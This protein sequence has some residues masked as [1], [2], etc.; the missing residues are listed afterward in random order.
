MVVDEKRRADAFMPFRFPADQLGSVFAGDRH[1]DCS[2]GSNGFHSVFED[3]R[4]TLINPAPRQLG[5]PACPLIVPVPSSS[6]DDTPPPSLVT[7]AKSAFKQL[8][9]PTSRSKTRPKEKGKF[10]LSDD[11]DEDDTD[12]DSDVEEE[13]TTPAKSK[14]KAKAGQPRK[15][16]K[17]KAKPS[18]AFNRG[19]FHALRPATNKYYN[20]ESNLIHLRCAEHHARRTTVDACNQHIENRKDLIMTLRETQHKLTGRERAQFSQARADE[21]ATALLTVQKELKALEATTARYQLDTERMRL[22]LQKTEK[23]AEESES[24]AEQQVDMDRLNAIRRNMMGT[25]AGPST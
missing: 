7:K 2:R 8:V 24:S 22:Q 17:A 23:E 13:P 16:R 20:Q 5:F 21:A 6:E 1:I 10:F 18:D 14:G 9:T 19:F 11:D 4:C 15:T 12:S 3:D 25:R